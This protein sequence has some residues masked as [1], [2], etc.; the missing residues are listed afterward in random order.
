MKRTAKIFIVE[1]NPLDVKIITDSLRK[2]TYRIVGSASSVEEAMPLIAKRKPDLVLMDITLKGEKDG[3]WGASQIQENMDIPV[4]FLS[5]F[6]SDKIKK[7]ILEADPSGFLVKPYNEQELHI[8]VE[9][10]LYKAFM[11]K[12]LNRKEVRF[13]SMVKALPDLLIN[14]DQNGN[15]LE[16]TTQ[17]E[18]TLPIDCESVQGK[19]IMEVLP[20]PIAKKV[21][22]SIQRAIKTGNMQT[23]EYELETGKGHRIFE[24]RIA[25]SVQQEAVAIIRDVTE[26]RKTEKELIYMRFRDRMTDLYNRDFF[27][28]EIQRL[29]TERQYPLSIIISDIDG[30]KMVNDILGHM[31]GDELVKRAARVMKESFRDEDIVCRTG[32]DEFTIILPK[33]D[34]NTTRKMMRRIRERCQVLT[35]K[36]EVVQIAL[37]AATKTDKS[38]SIAELLQ[39]ADDQMYQNK[40]TNRDN[41]LADLLKKLE[42]NSNFDPGSNRKYWERLTRCNPLIK[43]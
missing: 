3:I 16:V 11:K 18:T 8:N 12:E 5:G 36:G 4:L 39:E 42:E 27:E 14:Y 20:E 19:N 38:T 37:G 15:Y 22:E 30:L 41:K 26:A 34:E 24:M 6:L 40:L 9:L 21:L 25:G 33:T 1:D 10:A 2:K 23:V 32:G 28:E 43:D 35:D 13:Q 7:R 29:D 31:E 17:D